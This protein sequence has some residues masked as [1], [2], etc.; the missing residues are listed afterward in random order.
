MMRRPANRPTGAEERKGAARV[1]RHEGHELGGW[2]TLEANRCPA[3]SD[4][5]E[6]GGQE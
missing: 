5:G 1:P 6:G 2:S 4:D 3:V